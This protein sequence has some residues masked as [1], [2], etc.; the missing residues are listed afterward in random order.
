MDAVEGMFGVEARVQILDHPLADSRGQSQLLAPIDLGGDRNSCPGH[1]RS[2]GASWH[3][4]RPAILWVM[5]S[6]IISAG[7]S[8]DEPEKWKRRS[9]WL[10]NNGFSQRAVH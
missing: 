3:S 1:W 9:N 5:T 8:G 2:P 7:I 4:C 10:P 6:S